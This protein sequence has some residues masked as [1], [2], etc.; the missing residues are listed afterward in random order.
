MPYAPLNIHDVYRQGK[1]LNDVWANPFFADMRQWQQQYNPGLGAPQRHPNGN[2]LM[3]CPYR[4][5]HADLLK[6]LLRH[7]PD[8]IDDNARAALLDPG[9]HAG[10]EQFGRD[11]AALSD[12]IWESEYL[13]PG[14]AGEE[15][16]G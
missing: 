7:E 13:T 12:P 2:L 14:R 15:G 4:D 10:L 3:P 5:H 9:Y 1:G 8:P 6:I 16:T 11:L